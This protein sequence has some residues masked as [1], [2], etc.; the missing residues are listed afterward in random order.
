MIKPE[1]F[2]EVTPLSTKDCFIVIERLKSTFNFPIH[3]H[4]ECELNYIEYAKGAQRVVGDSVETISDL[5]LVLVTNPALEHAWVNHECKSQSIYE[6]TVQFHR[7]S[8][9]EELLEKNQFQSIK[10]LFERARNGVVFGEQAV[11]RVRPLLKT[12]SYETV[13]FYAVIKFLMILHELSIT[14]DARELASPS[15]ICQNRPLE[16]NLR[17]SKVIDYLNKNYDKQLRL[18][19]IADLVN[20]TESSF[21]RFIKRHTSKSFVDLLT[22]IRLGFA[23]RALVDST[24]SIAEIGYACG[25]NNLSNFNRIFKKKKGIPPTEFRHNYRKRKVIV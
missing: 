1:L 8:L 25:F 7:S 18:I 10:T 19:D 3:V 16:K 22:D 11:N 5:E 17:I 12:L 20:M 23:V 14:E 15:F 4:P 24:Q 6:I 21:C 13:G 9:P 2:K